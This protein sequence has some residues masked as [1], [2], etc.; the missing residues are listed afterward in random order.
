MRR[1]V[2]ISFPDDSG[3]S[4]GSIGNF[5]DFA[6]EVREYLDKRNMDTS[7]IVCAVDEKGCILDELKNKL[8]KE[9]AAD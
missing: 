9:Q 8:N 5:G 7:V 6:D 2:E 4:I 3:R 1:M